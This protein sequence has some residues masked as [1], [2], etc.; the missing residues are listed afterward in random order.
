MYWTIFALFRV[1]KIRERKMEEMGP[2]GGLIMSPYGSAEADCHDSG[3]LSNQMCP[4]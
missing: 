3:T 2:V 4:F 1:Q